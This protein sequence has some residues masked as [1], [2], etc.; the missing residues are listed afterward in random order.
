MTTSTESRELLRSRL[1]DY[2]GHVLRRTGD[3]KQE[4]CCADDT[5]ARYRDIVRLLPAEIVERNYGCGCSIPDDDLGGLTVLDLG[6]G[7]GFDAFILAKL[8]GESGRVIGLD[9]TEEQLDVARRNLPA[10]E[11]A[12]DLPRRN[13]ELI[14]GYIEC[15]D[16]VPDASIDL[17]VS[18]CVINLSPEKERVF[19]TA[20]RVLRPGGEL[21]ISDIVADR[22]VPER[23]SRR[24]DLVAECSA[25]RS[26]S[27]T[28]SMRSRPLGFE[29]RE[30]SA[31]E[32]STA[33][34]EVCRSS[35]SRSP[36]EPSS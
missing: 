3:L 13:V 17:V 20:W 36:S 29:T 16:G 15:A 7:A 6:C 9:M 30:W 32:R 2:Y 18:D 12:L 19:E 21:F 35:S 22:R 1:R 34:S 26:T 28:S 5:R 14:S 10:V 11:R 31:G 8:V 23:L 27:T 4:A 24:V 25:V 33:T